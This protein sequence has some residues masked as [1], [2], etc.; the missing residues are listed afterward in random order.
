M[1]IGIWCMRCIMVVGVHRDPSVV[2]VVRVN[3]AFVAR[4]MGYLG[5]VGTVMGNVIMNQANMRSREV[6]GFHVDACEV[7]ATGYEYV[8]GEKGFYF[9]VAYTNG[10]TMANQLTSV[11]VELYAE[12]MDLRTNKVLIPSMIQSIEE[13]LND[14]HGAAVRTI[15]EPTQFCIDV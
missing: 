5:A 4:A 12:K 11:I 9:D 10:C 7:V 14:S 8:S 6:C 13:M 15:Q 1:A 3:A 2:D